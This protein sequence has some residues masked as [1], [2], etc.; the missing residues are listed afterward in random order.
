[1]MY[2]SMYMRALDMGTINR[3]VHIPFLLEIH[4][5]YGLFAIQ[6]NLLTVACQS[7]WSEWYDEITQCQNFDQHLSD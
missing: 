6:E 5:L 3:I 2:T 7:P 1:M 4:H